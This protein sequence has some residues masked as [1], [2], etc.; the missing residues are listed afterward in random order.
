MIASAGK[1]SEAQI[2]VSVPLY[3]RPKTRE[4]QIRSRHQLSSQEHVQ[5]YQREHNAENP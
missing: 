2:L 1:C 5:G 4:I 3:M